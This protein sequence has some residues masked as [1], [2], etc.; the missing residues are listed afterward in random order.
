MFKSDTKEV[1]D[2][3]NKEV[4]EFIKQLKSKKWKP[5]NQI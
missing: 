1:V 4:E 5:R 2:H 3:K